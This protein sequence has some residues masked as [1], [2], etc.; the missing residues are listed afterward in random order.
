MSNYFRILDT[1]KELKERHPSYNLGRHIETVRSE[2]GDIWG[3]SDKELFYAFE[4]YF[5]Q[6]EL[7][8]EDLSEEYVDQIVKDGENLEDILNE[9]DGY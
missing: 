2:Y 4:K 5:S 3:L 7:D 9:E 6:L 1:L 8:L